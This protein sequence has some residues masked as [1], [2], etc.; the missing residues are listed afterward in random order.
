MKKVIITLAIISL[1][2]LLPPAVQAQTLSLSLWP[3]LLEATIQ[4]GK[5]ITQ[6]YR[7]KNQ[8][9]D[10]TI[11]ASIVPFVPADELGHIQISRKPSPASRYFSLQNADLNL[12]AT[13]PLKAGATQE[14]VL[15]IRI[16]ENAPEADH[17]LTFLFE[18][19][20]QG[21]IGGSGTTAQAS[22]G[23]NILLTVSQDGQPLRSAKI[24]QFSVKTPSLFGRHLPLLDSFDAIRFILRVKNTSQTRLKAIGQIDIYNMWAKKTTTLPLREDNI[25]AN[26]I[27]QLTSETPPDD[28]SAAG[29]ITWNSTFPFGRYRA[30]ATV[31]PQD[32]LNKISQT[33]TFWVLPYKALL[34]LLLIFIFY[35][36]LTKTL[37]PLITKPPKSTA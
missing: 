4:P 24:I 23:S 16:P 30:V 37:P 15:K 17:Y 22:I 5:S 25:L 36:L 12:P 32:S 27:R 1:F 13:F 20:T 11:H 18:S 31:T 29:L 33:I 21:L 6:V 26:T 8:G 35:R 19:D 34:A 9:D 7:L 28:P 2:F 10:T 14:L 3:P